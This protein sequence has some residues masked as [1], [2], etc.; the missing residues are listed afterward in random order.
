MFSLWIDEVVSKLVKLNNP[1]HL[2]QQPVGH[3]HPTCPGYLKSKSR[4]KDVKVQNHY[5]RSAKIEGYMQKM[6]TFFFFA[7][8]SLTLLL[9][10]LLVCLSVFSP[11]SHRP[12]WWDVW[13]SL[14]SGCTL[15]MFLWCTFEW[16]H[17][18]RGSGAGARWG[19]PVG[20]SS[21]PPCYA[22][23]SNVANSPFFLLCNMVV[24]T[25]TSCTT[26][27]WFKALRSDWL[28]GQLLAGLQISVPSSMWICWSRSVS[29]SGSRAVG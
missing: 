9:G 28:T 4:V 20:R 25:S 19:Q 14:Y 7:F 10:F 18:L 6:K 1:I 2:L 29:K 21:S 26:T 11:W 24:E 17:Y 23:G 3:R 13:W 16:F 8:I 22:G 27:A 15:R 12:R 5:L